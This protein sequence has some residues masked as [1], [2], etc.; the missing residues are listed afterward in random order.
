MRV[1][2]DDAPRRSK[3][4]KEFVCDR[5]SQQQRIWRCMGFENAVSRNLRGVGA[6]IGFL[7]V[8]GLYSFIK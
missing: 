4:R 2:V 3:E 7:I 6:F 8:L 5:D 1:D